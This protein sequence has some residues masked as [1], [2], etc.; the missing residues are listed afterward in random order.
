MPSKTEPTFVDILKRHRLA[1]GLSKAELG[2]RARL[3]TKISTTYITL[4][5]AGARN[6]S[7]EKVLALAKA[8]EL[9][10]KETTALLTAGGR[11]PIDQTERTIQ[12]RENKVIR[13]IRTLMEDSTIPPQRKRKAEETILSFVKWLHAEL[14][15]SRGQPQHPPR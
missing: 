5:E 1:K 14:T 9:D 12:P 15:S 11:L 4:I 2:R 6:P 3:Y 8:L 13:A 10:A 7:R